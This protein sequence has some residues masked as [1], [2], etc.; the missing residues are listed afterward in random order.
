MQN[1]NNNNTNINNKKKKKIIISNMH[2][3]VH[4]TYMLSLLV[5]TNFSMSLTVV[6][7]AAGFPDSSAY[8]RRKTLDTSFTIMQL[9]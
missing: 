7:P 9:R 4:C 8:S 1:N 6:R 5:V 2:I 3:H